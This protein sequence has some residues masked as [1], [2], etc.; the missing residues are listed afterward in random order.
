MKRISCD[1][2]TGKPANRQTGKLFVISAPSGCGK[3]TLCKKLLEDRI[4][5]KH[6]ISATTRPP[7]RGEIDGKD[8]FFVS[9]EEF[10]AMVKRDEFL[11]HEE[12]F[13]F[14][15]GTP[16]KLVKALLAKGRNVLLSI[17][18]KGAMKV[19][20]LYPSKSVLIF[21]MPPALSALKKRLESRRTDAAR[22]ISTR[23][24]VARREIGYKHRYDYVVVNDSL[25]AAYKKLKQIVISEIEGPKK[26]D[27]GCRMY[28]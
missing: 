7:R 21:V 19:G 15:Y 5:L 17:D 8:Y 1:K 16:K 2:R 14:L 12:N 20:R 23:L 6:S 24:K 13:G 25:D 9:P 26:G 3:T 18:V 28:R 10:R 11:E 27:P 22:S 4:N